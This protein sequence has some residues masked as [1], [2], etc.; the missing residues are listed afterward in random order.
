MKKLSIIIICLLFL[1]ILK[2]LVYILGFI[3]NIFFGFIGLLLNIFFW[4]TGFIFSLFI[5]FIHEPSNYFVVVLLIAIIGFLVLHFY[6]KDDSETK[7]D[8]VKVIAIFGI[9]IFFIMMLSGF[10]A[11]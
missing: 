9:L 2:P 3:L 8:F 4:F 11:Y 1:L 10:F 5:N 7:K 6:Y